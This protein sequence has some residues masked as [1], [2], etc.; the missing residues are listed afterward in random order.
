MKYYDTAVK[1][2]LEFLAVNSVQSEP[3]SQSPFGKGVAECLSLAEKMAK[4]YRFK[5][6]NN[7]YY[8]W[9]E[10]G[11][12]ELFG[13]LG[14][15]DTVPFEQ[16]WTANPLGEIKDGYIYGRGVLDDKGPMILCFYAFCELL[17]EGMVPKKR[18]R[19]I[20]GG[21]EESGWKC[22]EKY[23][24]CD[25]FPIKGI[26]PD[27]DF[28]VI[29]CEKGVAHLKVLLKK[30]DT[31]ISVKGGMRINMVM[32]ECT[33]KI[34]ARLKEKDDDGLKVKYRD[35]LTVITAKGKSAHGS[36]PCAGD[37][38]CHKIL[39]YLAKQLKGDYVN[40]AKILCGSDGKALKIAFKDGSG[41]LTFNLGTIEIEGNGIAAGIDIRHPVSIQRKIIEEIINS[42]PY[43]ESVETLN[44]HDPHFVSA[45]S[46]LVQGLLKAYNEVCS[47]QA[48][49]LSIGGATYARLMKEGVAFGPIFPKEESTIHQKDERV[50]L[51][52]FKKMYD[53]YKEAFKNLLFK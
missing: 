9:A 23:G 12:G 36:T 26:S 21:N 4:E 50:S 47:Q 34:N 31:L 17:S 13:V 40:L 2:T 11:E 18:V 49:P 48:K 41:A 7:G 46:P 28:P 29:N 19:F 14:H 24:E 51:T 1:K 52:S 43:V 27:G 32:D 30:P 45:E 35:G 33:A 15:L 37:N 39:N 22:M 20:F 3:C 44:F 38:A 6:F 53:I 16:E 8:V 10:K 5:T 25:E 42:C